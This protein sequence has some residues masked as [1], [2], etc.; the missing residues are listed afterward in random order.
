METNLPAA[1]GRLIGYARVS[2]ED[3]K[4]DSQLAALKAAKCDLIFKEKVSGMVWTRKGLDRAVRAIR[5]GD[6]LVVI[7]LD[8]LGRSI[9]GILSTIAEI[10]NAGGSLVSL[11]EGFDTSTEQGEILSTLLAMVA[12]IERR[13]IA[14]RT[15]AGLAAAR[16]KGVKLGPKP[17]MTPHQIAEAKSLVR[18]GT[19]KAEAA[20]IQFNVSRA[21]IYRNL[22]M[23]A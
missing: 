1:G 14:S 2:T 11:A 18:S 16:S 5:P 4:L 22:K 12:H 13:M 23:A 21:T 3:Q 9:V 15:K 20:G 17:K 19:I 6:K 7:R 8:R 10:E